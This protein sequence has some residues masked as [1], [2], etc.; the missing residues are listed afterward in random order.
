M[1]PSIEP[2]QWNI[3]GG[4]QTTSVGVRPIRVAMK[5]PLLR[6]PVWVRQAAFGV[7]VVPD[8]NWTEDLGLVDYFQILF[9]HTNCFS[10]KKLVR[11]PK[12]N[13]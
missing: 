2:K 10:E 8:V 12:F 5:K 1:Y 3:G 11:I 9:V 13:S 4:Q 6:I 7:E